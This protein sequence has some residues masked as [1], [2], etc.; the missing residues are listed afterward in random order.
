MRHS[1]SFLAFRSP[2]SVSLTTSLLTSLVVVQGV[3]QAGD[4][5][6]RRTSDSSFSSSFV[7]DLAVMNDLEP[8]AQ[9]AGMQ[10]GSLTAS[11]DPAAPQPAAAD[12]GIR[13]SVPASDRSKAMADGGEMFAASKTVL[14]LLV[15]DMEPVVSPVSRPMAGRLVGARPTLPLSYRVPGNALPLTRLPNN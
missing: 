10:Q 12:P 15:A 14:P 1:L 11:F 3:A 2:W 4:I 8:L 13:A 9:I 6:A 5:A 7:G